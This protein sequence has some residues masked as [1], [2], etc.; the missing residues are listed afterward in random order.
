MKSWVR[1][2]GL[3][4]ITAIIWALCASQSYAQGC[5]GGYGGNYMSFAVVQSNGCNGGFGGGVV[6]SGHQ[7]RVQARVDRRHSRH[8]IFMPVQT[9]APALA[10]PVLAAPMKACG[11]PNCMCPNCPCVNCVC[12]SPALA[13]NAPARD[14]VIQYRILNCPSCQQQQRVLLR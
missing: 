7:V 10:V 3:L 8:A 13:M 14:D 11:N 2:L 5:Q 12:D 1:S 6:F 9:A 4:L